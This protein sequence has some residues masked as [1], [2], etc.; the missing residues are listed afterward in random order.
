M[1]IKVIN[2]SSNPLPAYESPLSAGMDIR[3]FLDKNII[4]SPLERKVINTGLYIQLGKNCE[5]QVRPRSGLALKKGITVLNSPGTIDSDYRGEIGVIL[6]NLSNEKFEI[7]SGDRIAQL[8]ISR[9]ETIQWQ[10]SDS[11][12]D[13]HRGKQG[14]GS[15][16]IK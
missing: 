3:A 7:K 13:S 8:V 2:K 12:N 9:H 6:I 14:F 16:G 1:I 11:L 15:T 5:A 10:I 4:L